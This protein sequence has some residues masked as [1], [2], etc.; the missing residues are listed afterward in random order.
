MPPTLVLIRCRDLETDPPPAV[1][2]PQT[3]RAI[4]K[5]LR[6]TAASR[7]RVL[8]SDRMARFLADLLDSRA[9]GTA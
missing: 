6:Y 7:E 1:V 8:I 2:P 3:L 9:E 5:T 4:A